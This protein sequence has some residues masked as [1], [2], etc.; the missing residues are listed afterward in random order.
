MFHYST[1]YIN[2]GRLNFTL[3]DYIF[4]IVDYNSTLWT[5]NL[6]QKNSFAPESDSICQNEIHGLSTSNNYDQKL[7][8]PLH[9]AAAVVTKAQQHCWMDDR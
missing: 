5:D 4:T 2:Y 7:K 6:Q 1:L 3:V 9:L 8:R